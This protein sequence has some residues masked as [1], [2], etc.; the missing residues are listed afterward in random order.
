[1]AKKSPSIKASAKLASI[2]DETMRQQIED[3]LAKTQRKETKNA[4]IESQAFQ[5]QPAAANTEGQD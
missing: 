3:E 4:D 1:M 2:T 5:D